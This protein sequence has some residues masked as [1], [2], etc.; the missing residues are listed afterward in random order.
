MMTNGIANVSWLTWLGLLAGF[1]ST[2]AF[3]PQ[4]VKTQRTR[5]TKDISLA[6]FLVLVTGILLWLAYGIAIQDAP[7][8]SANGVTLLLAGTILILKIKHG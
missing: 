1:C 4:V 2:V 8:I 3:V 7:L 5:S 6:T